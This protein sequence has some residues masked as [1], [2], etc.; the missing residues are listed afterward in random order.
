MTGTLIAVLPYRKENNREHARKTRLRK[1]FKIKA[2]RTRCGV[3]EEEHTMMKDEV[4]RVSNEVTRLKILI[5]Q[6]I[7]VLPCERTAPRQLMTSALP[8]RKSGQ[9]RPVTCWP[10]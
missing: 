1:K 5:A 7:N 8:L 10:K 9:T 4:A 3:L 6:V 2:L